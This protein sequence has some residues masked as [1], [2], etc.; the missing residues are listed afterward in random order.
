MKFVFCLLSVLVANCSIA[1]HVTFSNLRLEHNVSGE[2]GR[3][4]LQFHYSMEVSGCTGH[5]VCAY[6]F[7]DI[8]AGTGHK[9]SNG[10]PMIAK[11]NSMMCTWETTCS[12]GDWWVALYN[13]SLNPLSGTRTYY[14]RLGLKDE[15]TGQW[16]GWS[17]FLP[18]DNTG[19]EFVTIDCPSC[20]GSGFCLMCQG[21]GT[22][23]CMG[24]NYPGSGKC[25]QCNGLGWLGASM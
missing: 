15:N 11:G 6:M 19:K 4:M 18:F 13:D 21:L 17:D 24:C 12:S 7:V 16:I 25:W 23:N 14:T 5:K 3:K 20:N 1:Q 2:D 9:F 22:P 10:S 8:P